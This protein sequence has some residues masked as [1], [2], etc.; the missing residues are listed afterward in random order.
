MYMI[1]LFHLFTNVHR[2]RATF[3]Q[4]NNLRH[5][6]ITC[7]YFKHLEFID[8]MLRHKINQTFIIYRPAINS[9]KIM[10]FLEIL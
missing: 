9:V 6:R 10:C 2:R 7:L 3:L 1:I 4:K 8:L 5:H